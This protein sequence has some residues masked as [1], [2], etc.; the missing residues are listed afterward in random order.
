MTI[1]SYLRTDQQRQDGKYTVYLRITHK[2][3]KRYRSTGIVVDASKWNF[4]TNQ[5]KSSHSLAAKMNRLIEKKKNEVKDVAYDLEIEQGQYTIRQLMKRLERGS[6]SYIDYLNENI[7]RFE[8]EERV[9]EYK[10]WKTVRNKIVE[11]TGE[12]LN[13]QEITTGWLHE[14]QSWCKVKKGNAQKTINKN[15]NI[16]QRSF[17]LAIER[18]IV[19]PDENPFNGFTYKAAGKSNKTKLTRK[20]IQK[21]RELDLNPDHLIWDVRNWFLFSIMARGMRVS[22]YSSMIYDEIRGDYIRMN[23]Q[24]TEEK[25]PEYKF[26][27]II[28]GIR[29]ILDLYMKEGVDPNDFVFP[30]LSKSNIKQYKDKF[31]LKDDIGRKTALINKYLKKLQK[32]AEIPDKITT[33]VARHTFLDLADEVGIEPRVIQQLGDHSN[34]ADTENYIIRTKQKKIDEAHERIGEII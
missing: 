23:F 13:F 33:H 31:Q 5:V 2:R 32:R 20:Q 26:I 18:E 1:K 7:K 11:F 27:K 8:Q 22:D 3:K 28:P 24:K 19:R 10:N 21:I 15:L 29:K 9:S 12:N 30:I 6:I 25:K 14:Y 34:F 16:I 17:T 4:R